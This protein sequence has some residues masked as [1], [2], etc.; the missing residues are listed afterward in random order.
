MRFLRSVT[1][2]VLAGL[3]LLWLWI[4]LD[5]PPPAPS[6][7]PR[8]TRETRETK[9][10]RKPKKPA[11]RPA[12]PR[13]ARIPARTK[14]PTRPSPEPLWVAATP[15]PVHVAGHTRFV[16]RLHA[17]DLLMA[18]RSA[19]DRERFVAL[20]PH[21]LAADGFRTRD[22]RNMQAAFN[23]LT[24][25]RR[26]TGAL[27]LSGGAPRGRLVRVWTRGPAYPEP[28]RESAEEMLRH[29]HEQSGLSIP[30]GI[31]VLVTPRLG[32]EVFPALG[33]VRWAAGVYYGRDGFCSVRLDL[34]GPVRRLVLRHEC[35]HALCRAIKGPRLITEGLAEYLSYARRG[36][37]GLDVPLERFRHNFAMLSWFIDEL[38]RRGVSLELLEPARL[39]AL[40]PRAFYGLR[41]LGYL[42]AQ[43]TVAHA[44]G[45][46]VNEA[47]RAGSAAPLRSAIE[48]LSLADLR[49]FVATHGRGGEKELAQA[50]DEGRP[51]DAL[52]AKELGLDLAVRPTGLMK[53]AAMVRH[54]RELLRDA[55]P[56]VFIDR[57]RHATAEI[58][59]TVRRLLASFPDGRPMGLDDSPAPLEDVEID[60]T[61]PYDP[62]TYLHWLKKNEATAAPLVICV[63][64]PVRIERYEKVIMSAGLRPSAVLVV[65]LS[66]TGDGLGIARGYSRLYGGVGNVA[67]WRPE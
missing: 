22:F 48:R 54:V 57:S 23:F 21:V 10:T 46:V 1:V 58:R 3:L 45:R 11:A 7:A 15:S 51:G 55:A 24:H 38:E 5:A 39:V 53:T 26:D 27:R 20:L 43:A 50:V 66:E 42:L 31:D 67:Y 52:V 30:E 40:P 61:V 25:P 29:I 49:A 2:G 44:G 62:V 36:D 37:P 6:E 16:R 65:D 64:S 33:E 19:P 34:A 8:E 18:M 47:L 56:Y 13:A 59:T 60:K 9:G 12:K 28:E 63:A 14:E 35:V 17:G 4:R 41:G 32:T